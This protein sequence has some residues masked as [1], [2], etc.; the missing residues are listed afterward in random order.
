MADLLL[1]WVGIWVVYSIYFPYHIEDSHKLWGTDNKCYRSRF[2]NI[3][4]VVVV[5]VVVV[6]VF[7]FITYLLNACR[8]LNLLS[9]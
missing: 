8:I 9:W 6:V 1:L 7:F 3:R 5:V 4:S 2:N